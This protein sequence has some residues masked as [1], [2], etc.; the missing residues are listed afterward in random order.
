MTSTAAI[1]SSSAASPS[2][3][4]S[5]AVQE[6][7]IWRLTANRISEIFD[8]QL[9]KRLHGKLASMIDQ[10]EHGHHVFRAYWKHAFLKQYEKFFRYLR[11][12]LVSNNLYDLGLKKGL[13]HLDAVRT[14][15]QVITD[16]IAGFQAQSLNV[17]VGFPCYRGLPCLSPP[18]Q[19]AFK[20]S[21]SRTPGSFA[22]WKSF[23]M[24]A[25]PSAAGRTHRSTNPSSPP[26][27]SPR[28][29]TGST[30]FATICASSKGTACWSAMD[31]ATPT[32]RRPKDSMSR[33]DIERSL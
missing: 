8:V 3:R 13:D 15:F 6:I 2:I 20:E 24:A 11:N 22:F 26:F 29:I 28:I 21:K 16:R 25:T 23:R 1:S 30:S 27:S 10:I 4:S 17:H 32:A 19:S 18:A 7:G 12:E 14:K 31:A 9:N 33:F 5:G